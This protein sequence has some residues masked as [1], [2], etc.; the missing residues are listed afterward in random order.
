MVITD[1]F[2]H[3]ALEVPLIEHDDVIEQV[4]TAT[5][6]ESLRDAILPRAAEPSLFR[7]DGEALECAES[8]TAEVG[9]SVK[10]QVFWSRVVGEGL[11]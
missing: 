1:V 2:G 6:D 11:A 7:F 5:S 3:Q 9:S 10:D 8:F 4:S